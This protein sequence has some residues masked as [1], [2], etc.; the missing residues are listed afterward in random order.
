MHACDILFSTPFHDVLPLNWS[1]VVVYLAAP[2]GLQELLASATNT[3][4]KSVVY[5][6]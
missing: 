2:L 1:Y 5:T 3:S 6:G 4:M